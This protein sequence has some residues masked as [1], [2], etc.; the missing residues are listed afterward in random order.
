MKVVMIGNILIKSVFMICVT[1]LSIVFSKTSLLW[2]FILTPLLGYG[3]SEDDSTEKG[4]GQ[5]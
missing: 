2:W 5:E 3:Y 4:G 1:V